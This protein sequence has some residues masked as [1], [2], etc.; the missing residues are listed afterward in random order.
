MTEIKK[1]FRESVDDYLE[2]CKKRGE[3][4]GKPFSGKLVLRME[5]SLHCALAVEARR[6]KKSLNSLILEKLGKTQM[7]NNAQQARF[8]TQ[9][10]APRRSAAR[11]RIAGARHDAGRACQAGPV[12]GCMWRRMMRNISAARAWRA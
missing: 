1:A 10:H 7:T 2:F 6:G 12:A 11:R 3:E 5:P 8:Q 4:P 9:T